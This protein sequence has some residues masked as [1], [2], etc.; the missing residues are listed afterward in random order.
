MDLENGFDD[1]NLSYRVYQYIKHQIMTGRLKG[2]QR[3]PEQT[4]AQNLGVSRTPIREALRRLDE[5]GLVV[6]EPRRLTRV[7]TVTPEDKKLIGQIRLELGVLAV[8][9]IVDHTTDDDCKVLN[10]LAVKCLDFAEKGD[11]ASCFE[12]DSQFHCEIAERSG[13]RY[14]AEITRTL[15]YKVQLIRSIEDPSPE[16]VKK[17]VVLHIDIAQAICR[18]DRDKAENLMRDHLMKYY[19]PSGPES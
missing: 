14:L 2:G 12:F 19:F 4:I 8:H 10:E 5:H 7:A 13:N 17:K 1:S 16:S 3:I 11:I 18:H 15:D 9:L 6:I